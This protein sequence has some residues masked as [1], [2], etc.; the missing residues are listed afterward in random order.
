MS[1]VV[2]LAPAPWQSTPTRV[3]QLMTR[4][5]GAE[6][7]YIEPPGKPGEHRRPGRKVRPHVTAYTLPS[8]WNAGSRQGFRFRRNQRRAADF[9]QSLLRRA[10]ER[11]PLLWCA[12]PWGVHLLDYLSYKGLVYDCDRYW[13]GLP[14]DWESDLALSADVIFAASAG[15][16]D[17]LAPCCQNIAVVPNGCNYP[18]FAREDIETPAELRDLIGPL[19]GYAGTLWAD[20]DYSP[21]FTGVAAHPDWNFLLL[22]R[23]ED[24][25]ALQKLRALPQVILADRCPL[26]QVPDYVRQC[27][28]CLDLRRGDEA[29][30]VLPGRVFE[31][32]AAGKPVA[33]HAFP[34]ELDDQPGLIYR[35]DDP[36]GVVAA[37]E[38]AIREENVWRRQRRREAGEAASWEHRA[39]E[40]QRVLESSALL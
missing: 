34:G 21:I 23:Q 3:Q 17:R 11:D 4:L 26:I 15:L 29:N 1:V 28:V 10:G 38:Q 35:S 20:L 40:V 14:L 13:A 12:T 33:R 5:R 36:H 32:L 30:D 24:S 39:D 18:M 22:G 9:I 25:P 6:V 27:D 16:A 8:F 31:Y 37:C 7:L 2:C 19:V